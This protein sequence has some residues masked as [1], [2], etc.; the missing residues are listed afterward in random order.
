MTTRWR[1]VHIPSQIAVVVCSAARSQLSQLYLRA[2]GRREM[3][4]Y[5]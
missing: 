1:Q 5:P 3:D 2:A 4:V